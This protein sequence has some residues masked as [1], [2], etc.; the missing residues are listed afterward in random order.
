MSCTDCL[1]NVVCELTCSETTPI[2]DYNGAGKCVSECGGDNS[3]VNTVPKNGFRTPY[4]SWCGPDCTDCGLSDINSDHYE[5]KECSR[6][7]HGHE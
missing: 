2:H 5:C 1:D 4:C 7:V 3:F 6:S